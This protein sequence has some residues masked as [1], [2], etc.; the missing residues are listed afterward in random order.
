MSDI[1]KALT[2]IVGENY[3]SYQPEE[4]FFYARDQGR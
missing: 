2:E 1:Y 4:L 3:V